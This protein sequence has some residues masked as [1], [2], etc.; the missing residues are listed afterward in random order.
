LLL[1]LCYYQ[2]TV[3]LINVSDSF[4][5]A[6]LTPRKLSKVHQQWEKGN[7]NADP[8]KMDP[9]DVIGA[10]DAPRMNPHDGLVFGTLCQV[11]MEQV[12]A[13]NP[14]CGC[15]DYRGLKRSEC[16]D[17][18]F[19]PTLRMKNAWIVLRKN[20]RRVRSQEHKKAWRLWRT[21]QRD[22][23]L[24]GH[25]VLRTQA[26]YGGVDAR[27]GNHIRDF[28]NFVF[29]NYCYLGTNDCVVCEDGLGVNRAFNFCNTCKAWEPFREIWKSVHARHR[30][31]NSFCSTHVRKATYRTRRRLKLERIQK[32]TK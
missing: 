14:D 24:L 26:G 16:K 23:L 28:M 27:V 22:I 1:L 4:S 30:A 20:K 32:K 11:C 8:P 3:C 18:L 6:G 9:Q 19:F 21:S 31:Q 17:G 5:M 12:T 10:I 2:F 13:T 29:E 15:V 7:P 25:P